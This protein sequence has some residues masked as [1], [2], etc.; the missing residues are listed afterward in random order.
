LVLINPSLIKII[1][2]TI[3]EEM[4]GKNS[5]EWTIPIGPSSIVTAIWKKN[6]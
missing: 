6:N 4:N 1:N 3:R 2:L 5:R